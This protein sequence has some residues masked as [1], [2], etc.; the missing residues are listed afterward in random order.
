VVAEDPR[1][2]RLEPLTGQRLALEPQDAVRP[3]GAA[4][5]SASLVHRG[6][7]GAL[8]APDPGQLLLVLHAAARDEERPVPRDLDAA[9]AQPVGDLEREVRRDDDL[10]QA[11]LGAHA[12]RHLAEDLAVPQPLLLELVAPE[13]LERVHL[14]PGPGRLD[15]LH[16]EAP[17]DGDAA[18]TL[19]DVEERV[20]DGDRHLVQD[21]GVPY[22][23]AD[24]DDA[25]HGGGSYTPRARFRPEPRG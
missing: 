24:D 4:K 8:R 15:P 17:D 14:E 16:L 12:H 19:L 3:V 9:L 10:L 1:D 23:I 13:A 5:K 11:E 18:V 22:R 20:R 25:V 21:L 7:A 6:L 2:R